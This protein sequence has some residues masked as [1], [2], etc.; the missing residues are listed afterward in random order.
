M[1]NFGS[2]G[3]CRFCKPDSVMQ[4]NQ[5]DRD[6]PK[7]QTRHKPDRNPTKQADFGLSGLA[8]LAVVLKEACFGHQNEGLSGLSGLGQTVNPTAGSAK[9]MAYDGS[10]V[11][12]PTE[13]YTN[14][15]IGVGGG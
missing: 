5:I 15:T 3:L 4:Q 14:P 7:M 11:L 6:T 9:T 10:K 2:V 12:D 8:C 1:R 13:P